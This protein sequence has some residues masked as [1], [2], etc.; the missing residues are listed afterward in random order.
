VRRKGLG[1]VLVAIAGVLVGGC[2]KPPGVDGDLT[3]GWPALPKA[4][5]AAPTAPACYSI[6]QRDPTLVTKFPAPVECTEAHNIETIYVGKFTGADG[7]RTTPPAVG[8]PARRAAYEQCASQAKTYLGDDWRTGNMDL[9]LVTPIPLHWEAGARWFR[10]DA[11]EYKDLKSYEIVNRTS[12][13][14]DALSAG[15]PLRISCLTITASSA[16]EVTTMVGS[17]CDTPHNGEFAGVWEAPDGPYVDDRNARTATN[18][19]GCRGVVA[20][21]AGIPNDGNF[22]YRTGQVASPH[23][24][25]K[26]AWDLGNRGVRCYIWT[27]KNVTKSLKGAGTAG[28]PINYG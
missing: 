26:T 12:S 27:G 22:Q 13:V 9:F 21:Y 14:K 3:N 11:M 8:S 24:S 15:G 10:C 7:D 19:T 16:N 17:A 5:I 6:T 18:L 28:L 2:S 23:W 25:G 1:V 20:A 4:E